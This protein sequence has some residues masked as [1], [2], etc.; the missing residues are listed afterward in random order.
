VRNPRVAIVGAGMSGLLMG[1]K[2]AEAGFRDFEI[3]EKADALGGTWRDN[4]YPGLSCDIPSRYY[5]YS[6]A[7]NPDWSRVFSPG[8]E[9]LRY[10]EEIADR[11]GLRPHLRLGTKVESGRFEDG[12]WHLRT[13][14]GEQGSYDFLISACGVLHH[15]R[16]PRIEGIESFAGNS[17][18][19]AQWDD[20]LQLAGKRIGL[21]GNGSTGV[22][23]VAG[24]AGEVGHLTLFQ[25][26]PQWIMPLPNPRYTRLG[27]RV[28]ASR[29]LSR[30]GYRFYQAAYER[31]L[32]RGMVEPGWQRRMM[33]WVCRQNLRLVRD[34]ELRRRLTP[35]Y[36][37][38]C[39]R[40]V[41]SAGF[42]PA[43]N[44]DNVELVTERI[45]R[46]EE[47]GVVTGDGRLHELDVLVFATGFDA[48]AF[49]RPMELVG[50]EGHTLEEVWSRDPRA[51]QTVALPRFPNFFLLVGPH[52]PYGNQ[53][54]IMIS[55]TQVAYVMQWIALWAA[56]KV[57]RMAPRQDA[58]ER[59]NADVREAMPATVWVAGCNSW[60]LDSE[61]V[62]ELWPWR[63]SRH[64]ELLRAPELSDFE[65]VG[66]G[67]G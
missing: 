14:H 16:L 40:L 64:R 41:V 44:R 5:S 3:F 49:L 31:V 45:A 48:H 38:M 67:A 26:T 12:R 20:D 61:G 6:F 34:R 51:Y 36:Q 1:I 10:L 30:L 59:F 50:E 32:T 17:F 19:T 58:M 47:K 13:E 53:S 8:P 4:R 18:H 24:I 9:I 7:H 27:R 52:S 21:I 37:A 54:V 46:I 65:V 2:L 42:Y 62:P 55:E 22:Q 57:D 15:P 29:S 11:Y 60:Y 35:D 56:G 28:G 66:G 25:R 23:I 43:M 39:K 33:S 63:Q